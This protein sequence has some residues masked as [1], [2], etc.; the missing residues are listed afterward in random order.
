MARSLEQAALANSLDPLL[1]AALVQIESA[2]DADAVSPSGAV[3]LGQLMPFTAEG[4]GVDSADPDQNLQGA[5]RML[6]GLLREWQHLENP[7]AAAL[8]AYNSGP[9]RV[10][11]LGGRVPALPEPTNY[12]FFIGYVHRNLV[13]AARTFSV[14]G[15]DLGP[16]AT[17]RP[18]P[19]R[20]PLGS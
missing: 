11:R 5:A 14:V 19:A 10:R 2:F 8:S 20:V 15:A 6:A 18:A 1:L 12:V 9:N 16:E 17:S 13:R 7:R 4:L 3:G